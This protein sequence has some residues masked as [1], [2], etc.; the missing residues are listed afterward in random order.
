M[1]FRR[2][3]L[4]SPV[5]VAALC[6]AFVAA[7]AGAAISGTAF[8]VDGKKIS[9][10][11]F[12]AELDTLAANKPLAKQLKA[13]GV[14]AVR[15]G[16]DKYDAAIAA[17][18]LTSEIQQ[19]VADS[20]FARKKLKLSADQRA[21]AKSQIIAQFSTPSAPEAGVPIVN[22]F[23]AKFRQTLIDRQARLIALID[24]Q[25][26]GPPGEAELATY[27]AAHRTDLESGC[28]SKKL[29]RHIETKTKAQA[30]AIEK[31]LAAGGDFA[32]LAKSDSTDRTSGAVGGELGCLVEKQFVAD[33]QT[34][35]EALPLNQLSA[36]VHV[37]NSWHIIQ[38]QNMEYANE[39]GQIR[40]AIQQEDA[41][42]FSADFTKQ[43][44]AAKISIDKRWGKLVRTDKGVE[45]QAPGTK[46]TTTTVAPTT[47]AP[48][49]TAPATTAA[50]APGSSG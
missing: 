16:S 27:Y 49:T 42:K 48:A 8:S 9:N 4:V 28:T 7:P 3:R 46:P 35:A 17:S 14:K 38:V 25:G 45:V 18:W 39:K 11:S 47:T 40:L 21:E 43:L 33:F 24:A 36:P 34:A 6:V 2:I 15:T 29:V 37:A 1:I 41:N 30:D 31:K 19:S 23:P 12:T 44:A 13:S 26:G 32:A 50:P 20:D 5:L 10:S 22:G